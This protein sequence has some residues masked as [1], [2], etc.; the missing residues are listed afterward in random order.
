QTPV[1]GIAAGRKHPRHCFASRKS[2]ARVRSAPRC[3][4]ASEP[5]S[6]WTPPKVDSGWIRDQEVG[7]SLLVGSN[8]DPVYQLVE[9]LPSI[10]S[11]HGVPNQIVRASRN[12]E[13][14]P[15]PTQAT[16]PSG[17][18][19]TPVGAVTAPITGSSHWPRYSA[20]ISW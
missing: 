13:S 14:V 4:T 19:N 12:P 7:P 9:K 3:L 2:S 5:V 10:P 20:S 8:L 15:S 16:Y 18:I 6:R 17:R 11:R 1:Q